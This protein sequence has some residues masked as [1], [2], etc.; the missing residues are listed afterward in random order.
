[1]I[2]RII[3]SQLLED[4]FQGKAVIVMGPRQVGKTTLLEMIRS[5]TEAKTMWLNCDEP[6]IRMLLE[7]A[8]ST[9]LKEIIGDVS[10]VFIDEAQRVRNIGITLKLMVD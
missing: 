1:M 2:P 4:M 7:N 8:N 5:V 3:Q 9:Q 6:D 10:L